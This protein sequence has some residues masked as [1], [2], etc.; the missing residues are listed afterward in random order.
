MENLE[1]EVW[2]PVVGY[3]KYYEVSNLG[4]VKSLDRTVIDSRGYVYHRKG[5]IMKGSYDGS[6]YLFL[7]MRV[8]C[9]EVKVKIHRLV[10]QAFLPNPENKPQVNHKNGIKDDNRLENLEW[11]T[12]LENKTH[13]YDVIKT[14]VFGERNGTAKLKEKD[15]FMIRNMDVSKYGDRILVAKMFG[16]SPCAIDNV[17]RGTTWK[18]TI[19]NNGW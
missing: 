11:C 10:C 15:V 2:L 4:K 3:E 17:R 12:A 14:G 1:N 13:S 5:K 9:V 8:E 7:S 19:K 18:R 16:V 6:R